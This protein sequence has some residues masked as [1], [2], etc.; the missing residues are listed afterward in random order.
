LTADERHLAEILRD[1]GWETALAGVYHESREAGRVGL[2]KEDGGK[3]CFSVAASA[4]AVIRRFAG[5][6]RPFYL[7]LGFFEP[8]RNFTFAGTAPDSSRGVFIPPYLVDEPSAREELAEYQGAI[9]KMDLAVG[10]VLAS[11]EEAGVAENTIVIFTTDHGPPFPR[12]KCS[13]YDPGLAVCFVMRAP[14]RVEGGQVVTPMISNVDYLPTLLEMIGLPVAANVQGRS[15]LP[16]LEGRPYERRSEIFGEMT[17]HDYCDPR[18]CIRT[19]T[20]KLIVNFTCAPFFMDP[21]QSWRPRTTTV[22]PERP[23]HAYHE[24]IE[25]YDLVADPL[26]F[27]NLAGDPGMGAV[28]ADLLKRL[29]RF[30]VETGDPILQGIPIS[31]LHRRVL[32]ELLG[33]E[34]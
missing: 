7:Q 34:G 15:F 26:E 25:L 19:E 32:G 31:P 24:G 3:D 5:A 28:R 10:R 8:H 16:L 13:V 12:A 22:H 27:K 4:D 30:L 20:H 1:G 18:R 23:A 6:G 29:Q 17:Y 11:L 21:S 14:G 33:G 9:R 2:K